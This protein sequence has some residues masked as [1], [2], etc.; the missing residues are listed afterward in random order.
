ML[1]AMPSRDPAGDPA[2]AFDTAAGRDPA[3]RFGAQ[4]PSAGADV[5]TAAARSTRRTLVFAAAVAVLAVAAIVAV[6]LSRP[7]P[8]DGQAIASGPDTPPLLSRS[9]PGSDEPLP[10][11]TLPALGALGP[12]GGVDMAETGGQPLVV[13]F[14]AS[15]CAP[16]VAEMPM[17]QR[18][19]DDAGIRMIGVDYIDQADKAEALAQE[20]GIR[21]TLVRDDDGKFGEAVGLLGTPTTLLVDGDGV[22]RRRLT[23]AVTEE[24]L[25]TAIADDL[26]KG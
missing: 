21:Y 22:V 8:G 16:C 10:A 17:L 12:P 18:V 25:R 13:N 11:V 6:A 23:G 4:D 2:D 24:Q 7:A 26:G 15:W 20:L 9:A 19:A 3:D 5:A 1:V 14:W